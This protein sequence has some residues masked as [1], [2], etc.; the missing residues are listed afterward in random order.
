MLKQLRALFPI[1]QP[2]RLTISSHGQ[3][4]CGIPFEQITEVMKWL[5]LSLIAAGYRARAH[6]VWDSP[7]ASVSLDDLPRGSMRRNEPIFL[8]RCGDRP[9]SPPV[10]YYWRLV[11]EH[12]TMRVYQLELKND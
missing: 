6:I 2:D 5:S 10:G 3:E 12:P 9:M 11:T 8:Y 4:T 7:E 1:P